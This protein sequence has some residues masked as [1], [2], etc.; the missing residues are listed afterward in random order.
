MRRLEFYPDWGAESPFW[1][2]GEMVNLS[3]LPLSKDLARRLE[4]WANRMWEM[5]PDF[6]VAPE[7]PAWLEEGRVLFDEART[8]LAA[9]GVEAVWDFDE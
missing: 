2:H 6:T 4:N 5:Y 9:A 8:V 7:E 3:S 1:E